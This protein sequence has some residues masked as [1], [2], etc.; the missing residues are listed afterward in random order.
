MTSSSTS[1]ITA[2]I[3]SLS[4][5]L[6]DFEGGEVEFPFGLMLSF[7]ATESS[8]DA[9]ACDVVFGNVL[10]LSIVFDVGFTLIDPDLVFVLGAGTGDEFLDPT[11][12]VDLIGCCPPRGVLLGLEDLFDLLRVAD[13]GT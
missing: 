10:G 12:L 3:R 11:L 6:V 4:P 5:F 2:S 7:L 8:R 9:L 13:L 1:R